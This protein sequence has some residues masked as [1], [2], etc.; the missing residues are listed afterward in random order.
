MSATNVL[1]TESVTTAK[2]A[3]ALVRDIL[4]RTRG[5]AEP[6]SGWTLRKERTS[7]LET[8]HVTP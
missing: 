1:E 4:A 2:Q 6:T 3:E 8:R 7:P 5:E